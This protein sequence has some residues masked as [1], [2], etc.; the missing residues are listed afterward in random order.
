MFMLY[1][2]EW[3]ALHQTPNLQPGG[4]ILLV[5]LLPADL[6]S[7]TKSPKSELPPLTALGVIEAHKQAPVPLQVHSSQGETS[8]F[9]YDKIIWTELGCLEKLNWWGCA[10]VWRDGTTDN[11]RV[12]STHVHKEFFIWIYFTLSIPS[13]YLFSSCI[14]NA[15]RHFPALSTGTCN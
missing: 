12:I 13:H 11:H 6:P 3:F 8:W 2:V 7:M 4:P 5:W 14:I 10:F 1:W 15:C 9:I